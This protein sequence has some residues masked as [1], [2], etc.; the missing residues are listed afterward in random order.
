MTANH[1]AAIHTLKAKLQ[2]TEEDYRALLRNL[3]GVTSSKDMTATQREAV[4]DHMQGLA[5]RMGVATATRRR[6]MSGQQFDQAKRQASPRERKVWALWT[7]LHRNGVVKDTR[8]KALDAWVERQVGVSS[9]RFCTAAQLD[10]CIEAL[11]S[12]QNREAAA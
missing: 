6:S 2:L 5:L 8:R 1:I 4:R 11:K 7:Q 9:L 12:W 10:T 3:T